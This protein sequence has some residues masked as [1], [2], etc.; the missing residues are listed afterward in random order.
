MVP[1]FDS[2]LAYALTGEPLALPA[3]WDTAALLAALAAAGWPA[4]RLGS[5]ARARWEVGLPWPH[6]LPPDSLGGIGAA[7]WYAGLQAVRTALGLEVEV[8]PPS[9]RTSLTADERRL[10]ADVPPHHGSVG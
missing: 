1:Q 10:L 8:R 6:P 3:T 2:L 7:Q 9:R 5:H 4:E